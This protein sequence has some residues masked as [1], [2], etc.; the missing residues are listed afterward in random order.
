MT[1]EAKIVES[2][3]TETSDFMSGTYSVSR[4]ITINNP[5][6]FYFLQA[7]QKHQCGFPRAGIK[8]LHGGLPKCVAAQHSLSEQESQL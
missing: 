6:I 3:R 5:P 2:E 7:L 8:A 4:S 1:P